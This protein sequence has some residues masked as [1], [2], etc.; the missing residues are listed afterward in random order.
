[1]ETN[2]AFIVCAFSIPQKDDLTRRLD[3]GHSTQ[4]SNEL[5]SSEEGDDET[6]HRD[7]CELLLY[8]YSKLISR[9]SGANAL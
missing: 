3:A 8:L 7:G 1:M 5:S 2:Y 6:M 9:R 4:L